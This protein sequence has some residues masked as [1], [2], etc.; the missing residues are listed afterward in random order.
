MRRAF[1]ILG[2]LLSVTFAHADSRIGVLIELTGPNVANGGDCSGGI[3]AARKLFGASNDSSLSFVFGDHGGDPKTGVSEFQRLV[4]QEKV[5]AIIGNRSQI[6]MALNPLSA[7][8]H[9]P[10]VGMVGHPDFLQNP[11]ALRSF[12][13][14]N[15]EST[16]LAE[17]VKSHKLKNIATVTAE[18]EWTL[19]LTSSFVEKLKDSSSEVKLQ[20]TVRAD[21]Q[22]FRSLI[23]RTLRTQPD[24]VLMN[25]TVTQSGMF[26]RRIREAGF[27]GPILTNF[28]GAHPDALTAAG[29]AAADNLFFVTVQTEQPHFREAL[30]SASLTAHP[31]SI[32]F[33]CYV[34][35]AL[36]LQLCTNENACANREAVFQKLLGATSV[37]TPD[38]DLP[39]VG[40]EIQFAI[41]LKEVRKGKII[42]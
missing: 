34:S 6:F 32:A 2:S 30:R 4:H 1:L 22:D 17:F 5:S 29:D 18:D 25:L 11:Y 39:I 27:K 13:S 23:L 16:P 20:E 26:I 10:V 12:P 40:R 38:G 28:W 7:R 33:C 3:A 15:Q 21:D 19:V 8:E 42:N 31:T 24:V 41:V 36:V 14:V 37:K 9:V 35:T